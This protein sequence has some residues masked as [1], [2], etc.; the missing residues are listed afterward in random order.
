[1]RPQIKKHVIARSEATKQSQKRLLHPSLCS[2]FAMTV[3]RS[4]M[5]ASIFIVA[6]QGTVFS[7]TEIPVTAITTVAPQGQYA[8][9]I[10][11]TDQE[12]DEGATL[13]FEVLAADANEE[14]TATLE[15]FQGQTPWLSIAS[16]VSG[17]PARMTVSATPPLGTVGRYRVYFK[18]TDDS[19]HTLSTTK[20]IY[21][22]VNSANDAPVITVEDQNVQVGNTLSFDL[23]C[24]DPNSGDTVTLT[25]SG[26]PAWLTASADSPVTGNPITI[27]FMG[28]PDLPDEGEHTMTFDAIDDGTPQQNATKQI[29]ITVTR[30]NNPPV[31]NPIRD[32]ESPV[33]VLLEFI[34]TASDQDGDSLTFDAT[35]S[36]FSNG[37]TFTDNGNKTATFSWSN[38]PIGTYADVRFEVS[39][40]RAL[41]VGEDITIEITSNEAPVFNPFFDQFGKVGRTLSFVVIA[42]DPNNDPITYGASNLPTGADFNTSTHTFT[43]LPQTGQEGE[44]KNVEFTA[45]D[46]P[47]TTTRLINI[48]VN[49]EGA[50]DLDAIGERY[51]RVGQELF[52]TL[53]A[54]DPN[55]LPL[56][57]LVSNEPA[58]SSLAGKDFAWTPTAGQEGTYANTIF[59]ASNGTHTDSRKAWIVIRPE[60]API[61]EPISQAYVGLHIAEGRTLSFTVNATDPDGGP[62]PLVYS[63]SNLPAGAAFDPLTHVFTWTPAVGEAGVYERVTFTVTDGLNS[64]SEPT[65]IFVDANNAP[66]VEQLAA[67]NI[68]VGELL[69]FS[70][71]AYDPNGDSLTF[72]A[73]NLPPDATFSDRT[74]RWTP[75]AD[76]VG[77][78]RDVTFEVSDGTNIVTV[79][80]WIYV[81]PTGAPVLSNIGAKYVTIG[82]T[83]TFS[84]YATDPDNDPLTYSA[85]NLPTGASFND[86]TRTFTWTPG[87]AQVG[88]YPHIWFRVTD[89]VH[90]D[91]KACWIVVRA[92]GAPTINVPCPPWVGH[93]VRTGSLLEFV[94]T[95]TDPDTAPQDLT[96]YASSDL[97]PGAT[98]VNQVFRWTP[99]AEQIG[100][101]PSIMFTVTDGTSTDSGG[102][103]I[104]VIASGAPEFTQDIL[105][106][107]GRIGEPMIFSVS[108]TDPDHAPAELTYYAVNLPA[109]A[110][111][112]DQT[113][114]WTPQAGQ[115]GTYPHIRLEVKDP[116]NN[117][118]SDTFWAFIAENSPPEFYIGTQYGNAGQL[119]TFTVSATDPDGD[120]LDL[121]A[122]N[123]PGDA[124]FVDNNNNTG[125]F[126]W[127]SPQAGTYTDV[128]FEA[129]DGA[130]THSENITI[131][132]SP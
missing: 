23:N 32:K 112:T 4:L 33:R 92:G 120:D 85:A 70:V 106:E 56:T 74:F 39:D 86:V 126:T 65:W 58:G 43:W 6:M 52:F 38:P 35:G 45:S 9:V 28:T 31:L 55:S 69:S 61:I 3:L 128:H 72:S 20:D 113:F 125:T 10:T 17:N 114:R 116:D 111:F 76:Q 21:I 57:Y 49:Y 63:A 19:L 103:W 83:L 109:G 51:G 47:N 94:V 36:P 41:P 105:N 30:F 82:E 124:T 77:T 37:A 100:T 2:G 71:S 18:A 16:N 1:M 108:A 27:S 24:Q 132:I 75:A 26:K 81:D 95:A 50:P 96:Y 25:Y 79:G 59:T 29:T 42:R 99:T 104:F 129:S 131:E 78:Y 119:M 90:I 5:I 123:L 64:V 93:R 22:T 110:T 130:L 13:D 48:H 101:Y 14:D 84:V 54:T 44:H 68:K 127:V 122:S 53:N 34:I 11:A 66:I 8:P 118:H 91:E 15:I 115:A 117:I 67:H 97:P 121:T 107:Y 7:D 102:T 62:S 46:G 89:G 12:L 98:F 87:P 40:N 60:G 80:T 73:L 88:T